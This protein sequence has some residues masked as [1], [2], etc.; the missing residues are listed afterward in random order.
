MEDLEEP[1]V[2]V[3]SADDMD[4]ETFM[5]HMERRHGESLALKFRNEPDRAKK[6][7]PRR[8]LNR[9]TWITYHQ[10]LHNLY[11]GRADGPYRHIHKEPTE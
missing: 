11:D 3:P 2:S 9:K 7:L 5:K 10:S 1:V 6:G 8:L 4:D